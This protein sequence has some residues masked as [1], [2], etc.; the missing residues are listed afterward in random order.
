MP[1]EFLLRTENDPRPPS[2]AYIFITHILLHIWEEYNMLQTIIN[3]ILWHLQSVSINPI[4][5]LHI[6]G[7]SGADLVHHR[8][9]GKFSSGMHVHCPYIQCN[10]KN[11]QFQ[12]QGKFPAGTY[13]QNTKTHLQ[14]SQ[15]NFLF[16]I[17]AQ[18][19]AFE[20]QT[21]AL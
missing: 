9:D 20:P 14:S 5:S 19:S 17:F 18:P 3:L 8:Q 2:T 16:R 6:C 13:L 11:S 7:L 4:Q 15:N 21:S 10:F 1:R 12:T